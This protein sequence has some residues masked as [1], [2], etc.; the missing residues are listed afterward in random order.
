MTLG[1]L[2]VLTAAQYLALFF[3]YAAVPTVVR[4]T[5]GSLEL[6]GFFGLAYAPFALSFLWAPYVDRWSLPRLGRRRSWIM[7]MQALG[8]VFV[9]AAAQLE[10]SHDTLVLVV[11]AV[12]VSFVASTQRVAT[13]GFAA[14]SLTPAERPWGSTAI[15]WGGA[16][17]LLLGGSAMLVLVERASWSVACICLA[18]LIL[19]LTLLLPFLREPEVAKTDVQRASLHDLVRR[20]ETRRILPVVLPLAFAKGIA[21]TLMQPRLVDLGVGLSEI[22]LVVGFA[23]LAGFTVVAPTVSALIGRVT[24]ATAFRAMAFGATAALAAAAIVELSGTPP[25]AAAIA[26]VVLLF[27]SF[28]VMQ[29]VVTT[30]FMGL[31]TSAQAGTDLTTHLAVFALGAIPGMVLAGFIA[32]TFGYGAGFAAGAVSCAIGFALSKRLPERPVSDP[33]PAA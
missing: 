26:A 5:G 27:A 8:V 2:T 20:P 12:A 1:T 13:L 29:V 21:F 32:G 25:V 23:N 18:A 24:E 10:P 14:E 19:L 15:G 9:L 33:V 6:L 4:Q 17:G 22:A 11:I 30:I 7:G 31:S 28:T 16:L 3:F